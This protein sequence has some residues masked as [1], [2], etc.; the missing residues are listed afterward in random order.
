MSQL[1]VNFNQ[2]LRE[3]LQ[4]VQKALDEISILANMLFDE[5]KKVDQDLISIV[6]EIGQKAGAV[7]TAPIPSP[8]PPIPSP[9]APVQTGQSAS[10][11]GSAGSSAESGSNTPPA[12]ASGELPTTQ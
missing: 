5:R 7:R 9:S 10:A 2:A 8:I 1:Y 4:T 12:G 11:E 6:S 3:R